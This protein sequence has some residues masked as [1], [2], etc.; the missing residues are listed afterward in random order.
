MSSYHI[1]QRSFRPS[2]RP[3]CLSVFR[4]I[5]YALVVLI[6]LGGG[7]TAGYAERNGGPVIHVVKR[8][9]TLSEIALC[10]QISVRQLRRLNRLRG[11]KIFE[12][13]RLE[14]GTHKPPV[15]HVVRS[16]DT[17]S[18]IAAQYGVPLSTLRR[19][20]HIS[21]DRIY[22]G[23]TL[24][25]A[26]PLEKAEDGDE[27]FEY[28]VKKGDN[29]S[30]IA[31]RFDVG[32]TLVR[33]L[34]RLKGDRIYPGQRLQLRPSSLEEAVHIVRPKETLSS[35]ALKYHIEVSELVELNDI[36]R[37][38]IL[39]GQK[40]RL[41]PAP[42]H[43]HIVE[44]G[45]ALWEIAA[46]YGTSVIELKRLNGL[47]SDR[48]YPG[49]ELHLSAKQLSP[50]DTYTVKAGDY[51]GRIARLHQMSVSELKRL[52][53]L[54]RSLIY[55][56]QKL[57]VNPILRGGR[58]RLKLSEIDWDGLAHVSSKLR[59]I[60][61]KNG[62]Y[63]GQRP[64]ATQQPHATYFES[65]RISLRRSYRQAQ[66]LLLA[67]D[68]EIDRLGL[69]GSSLKGWNVV[70]DPGHGG[71]DPGAVVKNL[72]G[73]GNKVY[74]IEDEYVYDIALRVYVLL[75][76][77][78][79]TVT[80]TVLSPNHLIRHSDPPTRTF[81]NEKNEVY[82]SYPMNRRNCSTNWPNGGRDGNLS[83]RVNIARKAFRKVPKSRRIFLSFHADIDHRSPEAPLVL[84]YKSRSGRYED[85]DSKK[86]AQ[87]I[88]SSL[89]AGAY[90]RGQNLGVLR[91]NPARVKVILELRNLAYTDH[92]WA[93]R[94][95]ELRQ[96]DAEKVVRGVLNYVRRQS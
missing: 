80:M 43:V 84:F 27:P 93:L 5:S 87:S 62:P 94:F 57:K 56:G 83:C 70:L 13:Q 38:K 58:E 29:L 89:G 60:Q 82:N 96:R 6:I 72:D 17:L 24:K 64:K 54:R 14:L 7:P 4:H 75:R 67:F 66:K 55:P 88:L 39:V 1:R 30:T 49:Q 69:L 76:L 16:G 51:L 85:H 35:I 31:Q 3:F 91:N 50:F 32:I 71:L 90:A 33:Q 44:R 37:S 41:K 79:A 52:N 61:D 47:S 19:L 65:P 53:N 86:F 77:H 8:G 63:Y 45:D 26:K 42:A 74:V 73:N 48:I 12:G 81:V 95:E 23:Q 25:L 78:G 40:L 22:P 9:E 2:G 68:R 20:N 36:E 21:K 34:N 15:S 28:V 11:D 18:E 10:Y 46:A 59:R 92:A